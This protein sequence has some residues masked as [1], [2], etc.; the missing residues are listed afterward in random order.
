MARQLH[1]HVRGE[2][3]PHPGH[4]GIP[5]RMDDQL[6]AFRFYSGFLHRPGQGVLDLAENNRLRPVAGGPENKVLNNIV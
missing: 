4:I 1:N 2:F 6:P 5:E 3:P